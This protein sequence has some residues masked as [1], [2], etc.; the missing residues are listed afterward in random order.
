MDPPYPGQHAERKT[1]T[2]ERHLSAAVDTARH[3]A[4]TLAACGLL[5][6]RNN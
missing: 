1:G 2:T 4:V 5:A 3:A 6:E